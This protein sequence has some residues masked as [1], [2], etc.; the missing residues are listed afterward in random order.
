MERIQTNPVHM[1]LDS[2]KEFIADVYNFGFVATHTVNEANVLAL[3]SPSGHAV[4]FTKTGPAFEL[5]LEVRDI[6][7]KITDVKKVTLDLVATEKFFSDNGMNT[8]PFVDLRRIAKKYVEEI[9]FGTFNFFKY[10][11][12]RDFPVQG[13]FELND[14]T[15]VKNVAQYARTMAYAVWFITAR[16]ATK[17]GLT[18]S[19][20][21]S[22][23]LR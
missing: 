4:I 18:S 17:A 13:A 16:F 2:G 11:L 12:A 19:G 20:N 21:V 22:S 1:S 7:F 14:H 3:C 8:I 9:S 5:P 23:F 10:Q 15:H 6:L